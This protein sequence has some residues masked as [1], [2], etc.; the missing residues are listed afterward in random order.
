VT[1]LFRTVLT[2]LLVTGLLASSGPV[3]AWAQQDADA[4][5][6]RELAERLLGRPAFSAGPFERPEET[7]Q[8]VPGRLADELQPLIP[9]P[10]GARVA[11]S[12]VRRAGDNL[13]GGE[14]LLDVPGDAAA[15]ESAYRLALAEQGWMPPFASFP[16]AGGGFQSIGSVFDNT[17]CSGEDGTQLMLGIRPR[18][19]GTEVR[20]SVIL[21][22]ST[23]PGATGIC[24]SA[25][26]TPSPPFSFNFESV[27]P[28]LRPPDGVRFV[29]S[30]GTSSTP[31]RQTS[32]ATAVTDQSAA[33]LEASFA[34]QLE[35]AGWIRTAGGA[36]SPLAWSTWQLP[37]GES[38]RGLLFVLDS[39]TGDRLRLHLSAEDTSQSTSPFTSSGPS[40]VVPAGP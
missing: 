15:A 9:V 29:P 8:L 17:F 19:P 21:D 16:P 27:L 24:S 36:D 11:G 10:A 26:R 20:V 34:P 37:Q 28:T 31:G 18:P 2:A 35:A 6:L 1:A 13:A 30:G 23:G 12:V 22:V 33:T 14:I 25:R 3:P 7:A 39:G 4:S 38:W 40:I 32:E 5:T